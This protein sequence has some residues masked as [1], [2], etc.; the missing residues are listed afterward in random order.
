MTTSRPPSTIAVERRGPRAVITLDR[1]EKRNA[2]NRLMYE[3]L[4]AALDDAEVDPD[5]RVVLVRGAGPVFCAGHDIDE[6]AAQHRAPADSAREPSGPLTM[7]RAWY[8]RKPLIAAVHGFVGPEAMALL[9]SFDFVVAS[10]GTRFSMEQLRFNPVRPHSGYVAL[11]LHFPM[12]VMEQLFLLGGWMDAERAREL[13]F[14]QRVVPAEELEAEAGRWC[15]YLAR[16]PIEHFTT[17][18]QGMRRTYE[19]LGIS[20]LQAIRNPPLQPTEDRTRFEQTARERGMKEALRLR[21]EG[22]D[23]GIAR[24]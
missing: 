21:S 9:A 5:V 17:A 6:I 1:P 18:K 11:Y 19:Q 10:E 15:D 8:F 13:D 14:V 22:M 20:W 12:R 2:I 3:E 7:P 4:D 23:P 24:V 16:I